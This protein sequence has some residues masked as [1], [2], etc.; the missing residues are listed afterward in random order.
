MRGCAV[1]ARE[2]P[3]YAMALAPRMRAGS[4]AGLSLTAGVPSRTCSEGYSLSAPGTV[5]YEV[6]HDRGGNPHC[7]AVRP[8]S[9]SGTLLRGDPRGACR[10]GDQG[11]TSRQAPWSRWRAT[12]QWSSSSVAAH[13]RHPAAGL[14]LP[15]W[16][17]GAG[18]VI[19]RFQADATAI[20]SFAVADQLMGLCAAVERLATEVARA[21]REEQRRQAGCGTFAAAMTGFM[22]VGS[23]RH[24]DPAGPAVFDRPVLDLRSLDSTPPSGE[25]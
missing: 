24:P 14:S 19:E 13:V 4:T 9:F 10:R 23:L 22:I 15:A 6:R 16:F 17:H 11:Q 5:G 8:G 2:H 3:A 7:R 1:R 18:L 21:W 12:G 25:N 20:R